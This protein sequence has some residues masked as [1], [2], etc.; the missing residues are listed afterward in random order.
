MHSSY[1]RPGSGLSGLVSCSS[2]G[3]GMTNLKVDA[4]AATE[5]Q[6]KLVDGDK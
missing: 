2:S 5:I 3:F 4:A 1:V 6:K